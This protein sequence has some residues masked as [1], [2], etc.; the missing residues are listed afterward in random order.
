MPDPLQ[1]HRQGGRGNFH[2]LGD[3]VDRVIF[4]VAPLQQRLLAGMEG[5]ETFIE[6]YS[7]EVDALRL[8]HPLFHSDGIEGFFSQQHSRR[9]RRAEISQRLVAGEATRPGKERPRRIIEVPF[10]P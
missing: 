10:L 2:F 1:P 3:A 5:V 9:P 6:R 7:P 8:K 4:G